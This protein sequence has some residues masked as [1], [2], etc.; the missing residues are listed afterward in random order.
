MSVET[1]HLFT[2]E[3]YV[4]RRNPHPRKLM[5]YKR[6]RGYYTRG[7]DGSLHDNIRKIK[8]HVYDPETDCPECEGRGLIDDAEWKKHPHTYMQR[9]FCSQCAGSGQKTH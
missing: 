8:S 1:E 5:G 2:S 9:I 3:E 7:A 4:P 6:G